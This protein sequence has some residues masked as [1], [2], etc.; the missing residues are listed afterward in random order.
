VREDPGKSS[1]PPIPDTFRRSL[2]RW[3]WSWSLLI[4]NSGCDYDC[5]LAHEQTS[6]IA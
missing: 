4:R 1:I 3:A 5:L 2:W 6:A